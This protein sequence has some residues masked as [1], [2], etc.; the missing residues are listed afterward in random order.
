MRKYARQRAFFFPCVLISNCFLYSAQIPKLVLLEHILI[1]LCLYLCVKKCVKYIYVYNIIIIIIKYINEYTNNNYSL[2]PI[3]NRIKASLFNYS[4]A[5]II[6][7][8]LEIATRS[9]L[10]FID[11]VAKLVAELCQRQT[12]IMKWSLEAYCLYIKTG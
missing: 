8:I 6:Q 7:L 1:A 11:R 2:D 5:Y 9:G 4:S 12:D 3:T 10:L